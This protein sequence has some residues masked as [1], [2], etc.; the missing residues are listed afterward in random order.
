VYGTGIDPA[1]GRNKRRLFDIIQKMHRNL[2][3]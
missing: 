2:P 3:F 1:I